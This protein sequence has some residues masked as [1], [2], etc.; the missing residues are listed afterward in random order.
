MAL[1]PKMSMVHAGPR[2]AR[3][4]SQ[5]CMEPKSARRHKPLLAARRPCQRP[6]SRA[7]GTAIDPRGQGTGAPLQGRRQGRVSTA[8]TLRPRHKAPRRVRAR[9]QK[10]QSGAGTTPGPGRAFWPLA[11]FR[12][13]MGIPTEGSPRANMPRYARGRAMHSCARA[14][15]RGRRAREGCARNAR[16]RT[17]PRGICAPRARAQAGGGGHTWS[18]GDG[19]RRPPPRRPPARGIAHGGRG[20]QASAGRWQS[21]AD[22]RA[23]HGL[24]FEPQRKQKAP[25][26]RVRARCHVGEFENHRNYFSQE[27]TLRPNTDFLQVES[28]PH[29]LRTVSL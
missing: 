7:A 2:H 14:Q 21:M 26:A 5:P 8:T 11:I 29:Y 25:K 6:T 9:G 13:G 17:L 18:S 1:C 10:S 16:R 23:Y 22:R 24:E 28:W 4:R 27:L 19:R 20:W 15:R 3:S 12:S